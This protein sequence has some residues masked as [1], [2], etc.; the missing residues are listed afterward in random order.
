MMEAGSWR[1]VI[2]AQDIQPG[3][4]SAVEVG[5]LQIA[6]FNLAGEF[7]ATD[8]VCTHEYAL[9]TDGIF[10]DDYVECPLHAACFDIKTGK[11]TCEPA[12]RDLRIYKTRVAGQQVEIFLEESVG[13]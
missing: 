4:M 5:D 11:A 8:N 13:Q 12:E 3:T 7:F 10:E 1:S 2:A 9:L 6:V